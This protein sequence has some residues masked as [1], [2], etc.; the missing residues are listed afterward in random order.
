LGLSSLPGERF[1]LQ[2]EFQVATPLEST[3]DV[4]YKP[5][6]SGHEP[7]ATKEMIGRLAG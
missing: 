2:T 4:P 6:A 5:I 1:I 3:F 7:A